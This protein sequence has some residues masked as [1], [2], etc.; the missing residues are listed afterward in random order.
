MSNLKTL[1]VINQGSKAAKIA[2]RKGG[3]AS[4]KAKRQRKLWKDIFSSIVSSDIVVYDTTTKKAS[5][6]KKKIQEIKARFTG[7]KDSEISYQ[8]LIALSVVK[9]AA[10]GN[11]DAF[12]IVR[13]T[14]GQK[15]VD[16]VE[17]TNVN[18]ELPK[19]ADR[20]KIKKWLEENDKQD[21]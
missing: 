19:K 15:P 21:G 17:Q 6:D 3:I 4:G 11:L 18:V 12:K 8:E 1:K 9:Q 5:I 16:K 13:D 20:N 2:G 7:L 10:Q 14:M